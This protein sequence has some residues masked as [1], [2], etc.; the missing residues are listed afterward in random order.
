MFFCWFSVWMIYPMLKV[1]VWSLQVLF[2]WS[3]SLSLPP[4]T[5]SSIQPFFSTSL[6]VYLFIYFVGKLL[7]CPSWKG[8][9]IVHLQS[10]PSTKGVLWEARCWPIFWGSWTFGNSRILANPCISSISVT[11]TNLPIDSLI[12][13]VVA[14]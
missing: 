7:L 8:S 12:K 3:L 11:M 2:Y 13:T 10:E 6:C 9:Y 14:R 1:W 5:F 4:I